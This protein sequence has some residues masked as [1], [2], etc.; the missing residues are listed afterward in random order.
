MA[1]KTIKVVFS[2]KTYTVKTS[3]EV[4]A[5]WRLVFPDG[6]VSNANGSEFSVSRNIDLAHKAA[7]A[8]VSSSKTT[9][10]LMNRGEPRIEVVAV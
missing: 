6:K 2:D 9:V 3:R 1:T 7:R 8:A 10:G 5:A 4:S